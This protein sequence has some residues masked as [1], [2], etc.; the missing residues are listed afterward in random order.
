MT[1]SR[2]TLIVR[3]TAGVA[4]A[5]AGTSLIPVGLMAQDGDRPT[6]AVGSKDFTE[7][8]ILGE[9]VAHML[10]SNGFPV[11][12]Q[13]NLGGSVV[14]HEAL[15]AGELDTYV[16]YTG[17]GLLAILQ[18]ELPASGISA[19]PAATPNG[20]A[21]I[22]PVYEIVA[23]EYPERYGA[24]WLRPWGFNN[25]WALAMR[26][27][28]AAE[29]G[30]SSI[31]DLAE[32]SGDLVFGTTAEFIVRPDGLPG[33]EETYGLDFRD[34][35]SLDPGLLYSAVADGEVDVISGFATDGRIPALDLVLLEDD[36]GF[37][38]PYFA[39]PVVRQELLEEAPEVADILNRLAGQ[40][41]DLMMA[42]LNYEVDEGGAEPFDVAKD[43]LVEQ[44]YIDG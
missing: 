39:A 30:I 24:E 14:V 10:E 32:H 40:V 7:S 37:F 5:A 4:T 22:D 41:D 9:I 44:G 18:M 38:P 43:F 25:T 15:V 16:E 2:R 34:S 42:E 3:S 26:G 27:D 11:E 17:T 19:T 35:I 1:L 8:V 12:R 20:I 31:S 23:R 6:V 33:L 29:L 21:G 13:F 36:Q 28:H